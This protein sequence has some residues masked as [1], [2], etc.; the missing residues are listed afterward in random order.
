MKISYTE[1]KVMDMIWEKEPVHSRDVVEYCRLR[2]DWKNTTIYTF[3]KRLEEK[4]I[5]VNDHSLI[6]SLVSR[7]EIEQ[8]SSREFVQDVFADSLPSFLV[9]FLHGKKLTEE[10]CGELISLIESHQEKDDD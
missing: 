5:I 6:T 2:F 4:G 10:E 3:L 1:K 8:E 9:A 7:E